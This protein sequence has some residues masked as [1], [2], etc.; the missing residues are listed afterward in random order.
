MSGKIVKIMVLVDGTSV[1]HYVDIL[2][3]ETVTKIA[4]GVDNGCYYI[5]INYRNND[6]NLIQF[7]TVEYRNINLN[8]LTKTWQECLD[9]TN[10]K[11]D[12]ADGM[13]DVDSNPAR[14]AKCSFCSDE[15]CLVCNVDCVQKND[16]QDE[17]FGDAIHPNDIGADVPDKELSNFFRENKWIKHESIEI[18]RNGS[19]W[20]YVLTTNVPSN[21]L[22]RFIKLK[23][24]D[25]II[26][27]S[28]VLE[29]NAHVHMFYVSNS[30]RQLWQAKVNP[31]VALDAYFDFDGSK[32]DHKKYRDALIEFGH[33]S[34]DE[35]LCVD[36]CDEFGT[37]VCS[38]DERYNICHAKKSC[39]QRV[40]RVGEMTIECNDRGIPIK[41]LRWTRK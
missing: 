4:A 39:K 13:V 35:A 21:L 23:T 34:I 5:K 16:N 36:G 22:D 41:R 26:E 14:V 29:N 25:G 9:E 2:I 15:T 28:V 20:K 8:I 30:K 3:D 32:Y 27:C 33:L 31:E 6:T 11:S 24:G 18:G 1:E 17:D 38:S 19:T 10:A 7:D 40:G 12:A 37:G